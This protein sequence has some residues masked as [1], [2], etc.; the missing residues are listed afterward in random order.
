MVYLFR[1]ATW[2]SIGDA[3]R[4]APPRCAIATESESREKI[5]LRN[6]QSERNYPNY[7]LSETSGEVHIIGLSW[8]RTVSNKVVQKH[9]QNTRFLADET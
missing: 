8:G 9:R 1:S 4:L 3:Y 6:A 7:S 2:P 5:V